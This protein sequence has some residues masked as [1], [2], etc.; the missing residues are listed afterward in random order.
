MQKGVIVNLLDEEIC[1]VGA[2]DEPACPVARI[3][4]PVILTDG[5][6]ARSRD[7]ISATVRRV[8]SR[9]AILSRA[10]SAAASVSID[11]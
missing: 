8:A 3:V 2:R 11:P 4:R 1:H 6:V 7:A 5:L 9:A 10:N